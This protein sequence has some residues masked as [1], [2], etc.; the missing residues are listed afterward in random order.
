LWVDSPRFHRPEQGFD[1][2]FLWDGRRLDSRE[3]VMQ[4]LAEVD[5]KGAAGSAAGTHAGA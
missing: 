3:A 1:V 4:W 5:V 2:T